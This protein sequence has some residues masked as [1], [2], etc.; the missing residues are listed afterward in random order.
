M[1]TLFYGLENNARSTHGQCNAMPLGKLETDSESFTIFREENA[2]NTV[3]HCFGAALAQANRQ[4][5]NLAFVDASD[6]KILKKPLLAKAI[7]LVD[8]KM[9]FAMVQ[10]NTMNLTNKKGVKNL[11]WL[12]KGIIMT[13][14]IQSNCSKIPLFSMSIVQ[15]QANA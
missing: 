12:D 5:N 4:A 9:Y 2:A 14:N 7:Q 1:L 11:V 3:C 15:A 6:D 10:L 13:I 8:G